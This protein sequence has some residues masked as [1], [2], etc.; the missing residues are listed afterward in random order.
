M[1][2]RTDERIIAEINTCEHEA[3]VAIGVETDALFAQLSRKDGP[4][5]RT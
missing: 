4:L 5:P 3:L 2:W 1:H